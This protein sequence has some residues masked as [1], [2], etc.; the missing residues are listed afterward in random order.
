MEGGACE[1]RGVFDYYFPGPLPPP[2]KVPANCKN[3]REAG[4]SLQALMASQPQK[5]AALLRYSGAHNTKDLA[6]TLSFITYMLLDLQQRSGG[7]PFDNR[8]TIYETS[9]DYNALNDGV[10]RY[11]ADPRAPEYIRTWYTPTGKLTRPMLAI[12]TSY[13]PLLP[14]PI[15]HPYPDPLH[16][17]R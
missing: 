5:S 3:S 9:D 6:G 13:D 8:N 16:Q 2:D 4:K 17:T 10:K 11:A 7:N 1:G 12:H 14:V 15:P